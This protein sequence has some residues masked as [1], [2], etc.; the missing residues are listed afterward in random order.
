MDVWEANTTHGQ[1]LREYQ[2]R[3]AKEAARNAAKASE[4]KEKKA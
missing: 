3:R 1:W 2:A 4:K